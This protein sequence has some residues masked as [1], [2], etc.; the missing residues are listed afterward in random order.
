MA[1]YK[2]II[3]CLV[4][5]FIFIAFLLIPA[6]SLFAQ[7]SKPGMI[8]ISYGNGKWTKTVTGFTPSAKNFRK[9]YPA[10]VSPSAPDAITITYSV[11]GATCE[12]NNG[13]IIASASGGLPPYSYELNGPPAYNTGNFPNRLPGNYTLV[14]TD[15]AGATASVNITVPNT[16]NAPV[17]IV[18]FAT[19][20]RNS[21]CATCDGAVTI[22][23]T[24]G[25]PP[26]QY[27]LDRTNFQSSNVFT[28]LCDGYY[29]V[30]VKDANGCI[31]GLWSGGNIS[32]LGY[33]CPNGNSFVGSFSGGACLNEA[34][35]S[36]SCGAGPGSPCTF[37]LDG[38]NYQSNGY[39]SGLT[40]GTHR[41]Y[42]KNI[43]NIVVAY[44]ITIP[45][46]CYIDIDFLT[47]AASCGL[48]DGEI[49][50]NAVYG[51]QPYTYSLDGINYQNSNVFT[52]LAPGNY[53]ATVKDAN[54]YTSSQGVTLYDR[55]PEL[56]LSTTGASCTGNDGTITATATNGTPP[57]QYSIDGV[58]FQTSNVFTGLAV[59][60]YSVTLRDDLGF[61]DVQTI[62]VPNLCINV[63]A[64]LTHT[65]CGN[66]NGVITVTATNGTP[67]YQYSIDGVNFQSSNIFSGLAAGIYTITVK[68]LSNHN[69]TGTFTLYNTPGPIVSASVVPAFCSN[70]NGSI[71]VTGT[72]GTIP[73]QYSLNGSPYQAGNTF[74]GLASGPYTVSIKDANN[75]I[76]SQNVNVPINCP[77]VTATVVHETCS[78]SNG[79]ITAIG[80][81]GTPPYQYSK[82]G[83][84]FQASPVFSGLSAG[85]YTITIKDAL[86][87]TNTT[88]ATIQNICPQ[89]T[90]VATHGYCGTANGKIT[91]T[92]S[93][94]MSPY[95]YSIDGV[96]FQTSNIFNNLTSNTYTVTVKDAT[97]L[98]NTTT[99]TVNN[100]PG[101][102]VTATPAP[103][104]CINTDGS[105][106]LSGAGGAAPLEYSLDGSN[107]VSAA[108]FSN[109]A[110]G[111]YTGYIK[112]ANGCITS[113]QTAVALQDNLTLVTNNNN[114]ISFCEGKNTILPATSNGTVFSWS[115]AAGLNNNAILNP[116]ASPTVTT[117][118]YI[119]ATLGVCTR[120]DSV[121]VSILPAPQADAG[122]GGTICY[123]KNFPLSGSGGVQ[124][125]WSPASFL[126]ST[127]ISNPTATKPTQD[128]TYHLKVTDANGC[129]SL[130][131]DAV[132][133]IVTPPVKIS[134]GKDTLIV[135]NQ[136]FQLSVADINNSGIVNY[137]WEPPTGLNNPNIQNPV[138]IINQDMLYKVTGTT[139]EGCEG[140]D[141][142]IL[143][144]YKGPEIYVPTGFTPNND[145]K[146]D[147]L[148][149]VVVGIKQFKFV[150]YNRW[151]QKVFYTESTTS[152]WDGTQKGQPLDTGTYVW[153]SEGVDDKGNKLSRKGTVTV[154]R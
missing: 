2:T 88:A 150:I 89:V 49:T 13:S 149:I 21:G 14:V 84:N 74:S 98:I 90:A 16:N 144:V 140:R 86:G 5:V 91:A 78:S 66:S 57:Y 33:F 19:V 39:F 35:I 29:Y 38:V 111:N 73:F 40:S 124:Y 53:F 71:S 139:T 72:G 146:N 54:G 4:Q 115:P 131:D 82:D 31:G 105:I 59:G 81:A 47:V 36:V 110:S 95:Q 62:A 9:N 104:T 23:A 133:V 94:G 135:M 142:I 43:F 100:Y 85:A 126:S 56:Y 67:P 125:N 8:T 26:Y 138:T 137:L 79:S 114:I 96:N 12:Y 80:S 50:V 68:D 130:T 58:N 48:N 103:A 55:C 102:T 141:E 117:K 52:G 145:G 75:C 122:Q 120:K 153:M 60:S 143:K 113:Q 83:V 118:Y 93:N 106:V 132:T 3:L 20:I 17:P 30:S 108:T 27:S 77:S 61:T 42:I 119:T 129:T 1:K 45:Q 116:T 7:N 152:G 37:S 15:A 121:T 127:T 107:F 69:G 34:N 112:D 32:G 25:V 109:L 65:T 41:L 147:V 63:T 11:I 154:I 22:T 92:G 10:P 148:K 24:G 64:A 134:A 87:A 101:A 44:A 123:G 97:G 70:N 46:S 18:P 76:S 28:N 51:T 136:P 128:I 99:V 6:K 151:G